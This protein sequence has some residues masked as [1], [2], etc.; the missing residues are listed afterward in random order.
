MATERHANLARVRHSHYLR[1]LG[2]HAVAVDQ[3]ARKGKRTF[4]VVAFFD[5]TPRAVPETLPVK[6]GNKTVAV[7]LVARKA[8]RF[9]LE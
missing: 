7:P 3:I 8:P 4:G 1:S 6:A 5:R 2:A 9:K